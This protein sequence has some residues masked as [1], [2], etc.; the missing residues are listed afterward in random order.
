MK[1]SIL[2][3]ALFAVCALFAAPRI[4]AASVTPSQSPGPNEPLMVK[5]IELTC[6]DRDIRRRILA[7]IN[8]RL[9]GRYTSEEV[10]E[11]IVRSLYDLDW[12]DFRNF[13][14]QPVF[15]RHQAGDRPE[16]ALRR[17]L[18]WGPLVFRRQFSEDGA[19]WFGVPLLPVEL[20]ILEA[21]EMVS[22]LPVASAW[23]A[24]AGTPNPLL[25]ARA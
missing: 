13:Q 1:G 3:F 14:G 18:Q 22:V 11:H 25:P 24:K 21:G 5:S 4:G 19:L 16:T 20:S 15:A 6:G 23:P 7:E 10:A 2:K 8:V 9:G 12:T 17:A